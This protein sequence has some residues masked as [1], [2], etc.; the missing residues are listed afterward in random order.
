MLQSMPG[1]KRPFGNIHTPKGFSD[2]RYVVEFRRQATATPYNFV[3]CQGERME[4]LFRKL[5]LDRIA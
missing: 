5:A 3:L 4:V 1:K 2:F